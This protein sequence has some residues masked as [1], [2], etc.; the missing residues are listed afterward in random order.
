MSGYRIPELASFDVSNL[1]MSHY[2]GGKGRVDTWAARC[3]SAGGRV[4]RKDAIQDSGQATLRVLR[5]PC[6]STDG[7]DA[8][9]VWSVT[10]NSG[11]GEEEECLCP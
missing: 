1:S 2:D 4:G 7:L 8:A 3:R 9:T 5:C 6:Q 11:D 10:V